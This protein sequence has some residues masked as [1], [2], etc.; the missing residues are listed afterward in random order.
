VPTVRDMGIFE[1]AGALFMLLLSLAF[2][3]AM[4]SL[5]SRDS[6]G[7]DEA[8]GD[9]AVWLNG[10]LRGITA[11][12]LFRRR[13]VLL[14]SLLVVLLV[15]GGAIWLRVNTDYLK[16]FPESSET[17]RDALKLHERLAGAATVQIIISGDAG[18]AARPDFLRG[19]A[20]LERF[21]LE[22]TGVDAAISIADIVKRLD[23]VLSGREDRIEEVP[24]DAKKLQ[25]MFDDYLAEDRSLASW[26]T[27]DRSRAIVVLRT[28]LFGSNELRRLTE[29]I[30]GWSR[31]NLPQGA[32]ARATG[33]FVLLNDASD[34]VAVSQSSSLI[35]ALTSIYLMMAVLFRSW[36]TG[37]LALLPNLLPIACY[38]GILGWLAIPL[39][40]T[41]SL[42]ASAALGLAVDNAVHMIRRYRQCTAERGS[43]AP[44][45]DGWAMW[46]TMLRTGKPMIL[47]NLMLLAAFLIFMLSSFVPVRTAGLMWASTILATLLADL[48]F[49]PTLMKTRLFARA[50]IGDAARRASSRTESEKRGM[51]KASKL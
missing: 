7:R 45:D 11:A 37:F 4:L 46:L 23:R 30:E 1:A 2:V 49:L 25:S 26:V 32:T 6:L 9:Y 47:A 44:E 17:V 8:K 20:S 38:F 51:Q 22:Q 24:G 16:I 10:A 50:A 40:I 29:V 13:A 41:T 15:G 12:V 36:T 28:N 43:G 21:A 27:P 19:V 48:I 33:S 39:D 5:M 14:V 34:A 42:V 18:A 3:P 31:G 35:I